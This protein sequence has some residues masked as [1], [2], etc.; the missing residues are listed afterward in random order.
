MKDFEG[1]RRV[2][3]LGLAGGDSDREV[4][5]ELAFHFERT[6]QELVDGGLSEEEAR[7]E[8]RRRFG[9]EGRYRRELRR[10]SRGRDRRARAVEWLGGAGRMVADAVRGLI[11]SPGLSGA[12]LV[13]LA[14]G[15]GANVLMFS[16]LDTVFL[17]APAH[18]A[19]PEDVR[20]VFVTREGFNG[21]MVTGETHP[22]PDLM[23][24]RSLDV[25]EGVSLYAMQTLTV[26]HGEESERR[27]VAMTT[28][29]FFPLL[30]VRPA[31]GRFYG[32]KEDRFGAEGV[33][34]LGHGY[35][36]ERFG[37]DPAVV[38]EFLDVGDAS[39]A[40][41]G[42]APAGFTGVDLERVDLW[43][44][45]H[46]A[47][48]VEGGGTEWAESRGWY[49]FRAVARLAPGVSGAQA[50]AAA[51]TVHRVARADNQQ[52]DPEAR[53][54]LGSL[55]AAKAAGA[56]REARVVPWLMGVA[57]MV[58]LL[59]CANV[60]NLLLARATRRRRETA[61][62]LALGVSRGR[63][64][65]TALLE[66]GL[67]AL[68]GAALA[69]L[70]V[71]WGGDA[72]RTLLLPHIAWN[73][74]TAEGR[75]LGFSA[76]L[77]LA[78][79]LF[80]GAFPALYGSR[81]R[82]TESL[83][84][85]GRGLTPGRSRARKALL[86][87]Q[88]AISVVLLVGTGLFVRSLWTARDVDLGF[89]PD[90]VLLVR[91]EPEGGYPGG[92]AMTRLYREAREALRG[93]PGVDRVA[94]ST[95][96]PFQNNRGIGSDLR[97][98]GLD[99]LP[100]TAAGGPYINAVTGEFFEA[101]DLDI[102]RGRALDDSDDAASAPPVAVVNET[103]ARMAWPGG[104]ALGSCL[105]IRDGPC[106]RVVGIVEESRRYE[107]EEDPSLQY[108][109]PLSHAPYPWPPRDIMVRTADPAALAPAVQRT[110][111]SALPGVRMIT[112]Q[113]YAEVVDPK[114]RSWA[115]GT[116]LFA[117]FGALA[118]IVAAIGLYSALSFDV[119]QRR[120]EL[121]IRAA[122]G[123]G[124]G[125]LIRFVV[126]GSIGVAAVGV[127]LGLAVALALAE[128]VE[129]LLFRVSPRDPAVLLGVAAV[130]LSV[131]VAAS[132]IPARRAARVDPNEALRSE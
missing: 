47:A 9:D 46:P 22:Y 32:E 119:A 86:V 13:V 54:E 123:A 97:I 69:A 49:W 117:A 91:A 110:L 12:V 21:R 122:L 38:G 111:R 84:G 37:G 3:R 65:A 5:R 130:M 74:A 126:S 6:V 36:R 16:M 127:A 75:L 52:Y 109:V 70:V 82:V 15:V 7:A 14:L 27:R 8:A 125:G 132:A 85:S 115:L 67:L 112:T 19:A 30:G 48:A 72:V 26:G 73:E 93:L 51:T 25:F 2:F 118:L 24:W 60:A 102:L 55:I 94:V 28:A 41:V 88:A 116:Y 95:T 98:P 20:R 105:V 23:D 106:I 53:V 80:A 89:D 43:L 83:K 42:V 108:Y 39:Y 59:T 33:T 77:A 99:S 63:L 62:R 50:E 128:R 96:T 1:V 57:F 61:V 17:R 107:L 131:A 129:P 87:A 35:W 92:E 58:L 44:P 64:L 18:I 10:L 79:G 40:I 103:M 68:G 4:E 31:M 120:P 104:D 81:P 114:Y 11:R 34:V 56:T 78:A 76:G 90:R 100:R 124:R 101:L 121:G 45:L 66:T 29:D 71:L 113:P